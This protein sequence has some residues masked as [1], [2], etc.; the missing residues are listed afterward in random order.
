MPTQTLSPSTFITEQPKKIFYIDNLKVGLI[1]LVI[2]HHVLNT[3]GAEGGWYYT[4][5]TTITGAATA[6][7]VLITINQSFFMGFFFFLSAYFIPGSYNKKGAARFVKDRLLRLGIPLVFYSFILSPVLI[8]LVYYFGKGHHITFIQFLGG[9]H[10]WINFGVLWFVAALLLFTL[11]YVLWRIVNKKYKS[12]PLAAPSSRMILGFAAAVGIVSFLVRIVFPIGWIL[13]PVGFQLAYFSQYVVLFILGLVAAKN[14]W[15][16]TFPY[17]N[18]KRFPR[19]ALRLLLFFPATLIIEKAVKS[20]EAWFT[21]GLHW[22]Q[23]LYAVW[24]QLLAFSIIV[25]LLT[26]GKKL[27]NKSSALMAKLSRN[28]FAVYIFHPLVLIALS[29]SLR[30]WDV[31]PALKFLVVVPLAVVCSFSLASVITLIPGVRK[32]I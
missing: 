5:K 26:Y 28:A 20:P 17:N 11:V 14:N 23:L 7:V 13:N 21:G 10:D 8:Y 25:A 3:Y 30:N 32:I 31:D 22:Q 29:L 16:D 27:W 12:K 18:G 2:L 4:Q 6:M 9:F 24:E 1:T 15:L 19:Y